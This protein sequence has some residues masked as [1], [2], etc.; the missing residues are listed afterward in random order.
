MNR[1]LWIKLH[2]YAASFFAIPLLLMAVSGGLYL[3]GIKGQVQQSAVSLP[4]H[5][6]LTVDSDSLEEDVRSLFASLEIDDDFEYLKIAGN[7]LYTRPTSKAHYEIKISKDQ[8]PQVT[9]KH[10][11]PD[12]VKRLVE[13]HKG[14]GPLLFKDFQ[15]IM[16]LGLLFVI[17][18]GAW[19]GL[20]SVGL[21]RSTLL[22]T[23][24][25]FAIFFLLAF[26]V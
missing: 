8:Q 22:T 12:F 7:T 10:N 21:R 26:I 4:A 19:L 13:L 11:T 3:L 15:K 14:H 5:V 9:M 25:G 2:L 20:S 6:S 1:A 24:G 17:L 16:A 23:S 18:S